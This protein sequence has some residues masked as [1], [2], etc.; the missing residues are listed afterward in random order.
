[1]TLFE[2]LAQKREVSRRRQ[3]TPAELPTPSAHQQPILDA[4]IAGAPALFIGAT[5]GSGKTTLLQMIAQAIVEHDLLPAGEHAVFAAFNVHVKKALEKVIPKAFTVKTVSGLGDLL[6]K[7]NLEGLTFEPRKYEDLMSEIVKASGVPSPA[8]RRELRERLEACVQLHVGHALSLDLPLDRWVEIM[9]EVDAPILGAEV[10][11]HTLTLRTLRQGLAILQEQREMSFIDQTLAPNVFGWRLPQPLRFLLVDEMQDLTK[12]HMG[13]LQACT[14]EHSRVIGVGDRAQSL[15]GFAGADP[16]AVEHF[17][18]IF[19][20]TEMPLS[21]CYRCPSTHVD[22]ARPYTDQIESAPGAALGILEDIDGEEFG[23]SVQ[24]GDLVLCRTNV[25]L[26][27]VCYDLIRQ[28]IPAMVRGN[29]LSRSLVA[30]ARDA[31]TWDGRRADRKQLRDDLPMTDF[32]AKLDAYCLALTEKLKEQAEKKG[33]DPDLQIATLADRNAVLNLV[34][35]QGQAATIADLV[36]DIRQ[37]FRGKPEESVVLSTIHR[38]K[39]LEADNIFILNPELLPHPKA[40]SDQAL[41]AERCAMFVAFTRGKKALRFVHREAA[42]VS[43]IPQHLE[44]R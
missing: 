29:D 43:L 20:A 15:Y 28:G 3:R 8:A 38:A 7:Q 36:H 33:T 2:E 31:V 18:A 23:A 25:P 11:L 24:P 17:K 37:L 1:M 32:Q 6:C 5:A 10:A 27:E 26:I 12:G 21:I 41:A 30:F 13:L 16:E 22:L 44:R 4:V 35:E 14:D 9:A 39:G 19:G 42:S 40:K 34:L